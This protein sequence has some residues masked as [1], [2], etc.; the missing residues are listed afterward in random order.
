MLQIP[1]VLLL[2]LLVSKNDKVSSP[3]S[4]CDDRERRRVAAVC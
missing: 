3:S 2:M 1:F 4:H